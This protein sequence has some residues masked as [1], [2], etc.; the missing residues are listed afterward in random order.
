MIGH[1]N[2]EKRNDILTQISLHNTHTGE[3]NKEKEDED[4]KYYQTVPVYVFCNDIC[5]KILFLLRKL[6]TIC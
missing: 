1:T 6:H 3:R 4:S 5:V 2:Y